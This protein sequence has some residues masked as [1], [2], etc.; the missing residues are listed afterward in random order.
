MSDIPNPFHFLNFID[1]KLAE[2]NLSEEFKECYEEKFLEFFSKL[3][4]DHILDT[5][6]AHTNAIE[7]CKKHLHTAKEKDGEKNTQN[8]NV[9]EK[10]RHNTIQNL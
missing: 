4:G 5:Y 7:Q 2:T 8:K 1:K 6:V 3:G 10:Q 9:L